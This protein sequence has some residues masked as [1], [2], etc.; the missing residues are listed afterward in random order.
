MKLYGKELDNE[1][2]KRKKVRDERLAQRL[3]LRDAAKKRGIKV[4][5]YLNYENGHDICSHEKW[6]DSLAGFP[7]PLAIFKRC[8][9]CGEV[10]A[11]SMEKISDAN[12]K[13]A[14]AVFKK[15]RSKSL[16]ENGGLRRK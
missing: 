11:N 4:T 12:I 10:K 3:T 1:L 16:K 8:K 2:A 5:D 6:E 14:Y 15:L 9:K 13:R 7:Y